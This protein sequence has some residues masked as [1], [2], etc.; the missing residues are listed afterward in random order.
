MKMQCNKGLRQRR[1]GPAK[2][3]HPATVFP[4]CKCVRCDVDRQLELMIAAVPQQ[5]DVR[6][7]YPV[8]V[9]SETVKLLTE[10]MCS[11]VSRVRIRR[12]RLSDNTLDR[13]RNVRLKPDNLKQGAF[14]NVAL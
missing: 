9:E 7:P 8:N 11:L 6:D 12:T 2:L 13:R 4:D 5:Q 10:L 1:V 14:L 3:R